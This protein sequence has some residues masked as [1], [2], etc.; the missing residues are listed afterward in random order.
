MDLWDTANR[1]GR[2]IARAGAIARAFGRKRFILCEKLEEC[3][4]RRQRMVEGGR[5]DEKTEE[6]G[7]GLAAEFVDKEE[8]KWVF[9]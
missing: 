2:L 8:G 4:K 7:E 1:K 3:G 5:G 6:Q 9:A